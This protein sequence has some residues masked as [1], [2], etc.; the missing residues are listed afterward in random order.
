MQNLT[1]F[2][3]IYLIWIGCVEAGK[4]LKPAGQRP[5]KTGFGH[6]WSNRMNASRQGS[7]VEA[8]QRR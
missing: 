1:I 2:E 7:D 6:P 3:E 4:P 5:S 8:Q